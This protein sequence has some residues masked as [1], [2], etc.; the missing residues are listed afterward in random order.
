[1]SVRLVLVTLLAL[2][3][4]ACEFSPLGA[5]GAGSDDDGAGDEVVGPDAGPPRETPPAD[6]PRVEGVLH[7]PPDA[8][9]AGTADVALTGGEIDTDELTIPSGAL[10]DG[11]LFDVWPQPG[12]PELAVLHIKALTIAPD[13]TVRVVGGRPLIVIAAEDITVDGILDAGARRAEPGAGGSPPA[14]GPGAGGTGEHESVRDGGGGGGGSGDLGAE[15]GDATIF[16]P[17]AADAD[18]GSGGVTHLDAEVSVLAG[19]SGGGLGN[20]CITDPGAGG[21]AIQ[22]TSATRVAI[23]G[24][25]SAGGGGGGGGLGE[26]ASAG[27]ECDGFGSGSGGGAG[28]AIVIQSPVLRLLGDVS[29]NGGGGGGGGAVEDSGAD[30]T[31]GAAGSEAAGGGAGGGEIGA[32]GGA[33]GVRTSTQAAPVAPTVGGGDGSGEGNGGGGGGAAGVV[34]VVQ[35]TS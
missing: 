18:G 22:L 14:E 27:L 29:A 21:G 31:D 33:G 10:P 30:G 11:V 32:A 1:M 6:V 2:G 7:L 17:L 5:G 24:A 23:N 13:S 3:L 9:Y 4:A 16:N 15:G 8:W 34:V 25:L 12:G 19:G 28:G 35:G 26:A 20:G